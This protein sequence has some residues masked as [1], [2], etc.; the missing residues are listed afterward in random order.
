[1]EISPALSA[2]AALKVWRP[3]EWVRRRVYVRAV[4]RWLAV[5]VEVRR[6]VAASAA[7]RRW[8]AASVAARRS[9][10]A[11]LAVERLRH[12]RHRAHD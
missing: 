2:A 5:S 6:W 9:V 4:R 10:V 3:P 8:A 1:M 12:H 7:V 11:C